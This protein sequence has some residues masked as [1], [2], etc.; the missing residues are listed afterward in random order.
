MVTVAV[1]QGISIDGIK[2]C[3]HLHACHVGGYGRAEV[4]KRYIMN[5]VLF[6]NDLMMNVKLFAKMLMDMNKNM[7][8]IPSQKDNPEYRDNDDIPYGSAPLTNL[9][10]CTILM[11][12]MPKD[13]GN[14][15]DRHYVYV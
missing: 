6:P 9:E 13:V 3:I 12:C 14:L 2:F 8:L 5:H 11:D 7:P 15:R 10:M 4:Q 1:A